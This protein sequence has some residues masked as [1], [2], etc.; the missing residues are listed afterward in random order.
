MLDESEIGVVVGQIPERDEAGEQRDGR[1]RRRL[2]RTQSNH[3]HLQQ[4]KTSAALP[5]RTECRPYFVNSAIASS[6][7]PPPA[8]EIGANGAFA[9][10][11]V[12]V[13]MIWSI[14]VASCAIDAPKTS[15]PM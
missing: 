10:I 12:P 1:D 3:G 6:A 4:R 14:L 2:C 11:S 5:R 9:A 7:S 13:S 8:I 15:R